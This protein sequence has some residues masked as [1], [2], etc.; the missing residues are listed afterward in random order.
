M[1]QTAKLVGISDWFQ[2]LKINV[3]KSTKNSRVACNIITINK[4]YRE[5]LLTCHGQGF[6][7]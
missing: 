6:Q 7:E 3:S 5:N 4:L 2:K 1:K